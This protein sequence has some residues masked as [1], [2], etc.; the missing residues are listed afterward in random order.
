[1]VKSFT[2]SPRLSTHM[3]VPV[4]LHFPWRF[5]LTVLSHFQYGHLYFISL[6]LIAL[7]LIA[8]VFNFQLVHNQILYLLFLTHHH[9]LFSHVLYLLYTTNRD[10]VLRTNN[11]NKQGKLFQIKG[12]ALPVPP[13]QSN[14]PRGGGNHFMINL[15]GAFVSCN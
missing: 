8:I 13:Q 3:Y 5:V 11:E 2:I 1:M 14:I 10:C 15:C 4:P 6:N 9:L 12:K 7:P